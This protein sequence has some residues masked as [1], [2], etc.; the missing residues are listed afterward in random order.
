MGLP[1][2]SARNAK[3]AWRALGVSACGHAMYHGEYSHG[4]QRRIAGSHMSGA[5]LKWSHN[6]R[7]AQAAEG[8]ESSIRGV[9]MDGGYRGWSPNYLGIN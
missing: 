7:S 6:P 3:H 5:F 1:S 9:K 8:M 4:T 2:K